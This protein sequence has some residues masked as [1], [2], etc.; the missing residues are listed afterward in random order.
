[1]NNDQLSIHPNPTQ[2]RA[3]RPTQGNYFPLMDTNP[4]TPPSQ[5]HEFTLMPTTSPG[6]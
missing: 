3:H 1:M 6:N 4:S 5:E 2:L